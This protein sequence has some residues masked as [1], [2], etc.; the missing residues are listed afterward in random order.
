MARVGNG[1]AVDAEGRAAVA[2][3]EEA[4]GGRDLEGGRV[5]GT[6]ASIALGLKSSEL[7]VKAQLE[8][9]STS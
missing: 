2:G 9:S 7:G 3:E 8:E 4:P 1:L 6:G 5:V